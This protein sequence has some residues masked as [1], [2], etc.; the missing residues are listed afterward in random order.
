MKSSGL[1]E[2]EQGEDVH[3]DGQHAPAHQEAA[4]HLHVYTTLA[5]CI[6]YQVLALEDVEDVIMSLI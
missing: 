1:G 3:G 4:P 5:M 2:G 6:E